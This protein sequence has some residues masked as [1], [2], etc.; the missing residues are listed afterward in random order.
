MEN[1]L[2]L[3]FGFCWSVVRSA[4]CFLVD[5]ECGWRRIAGML[6]PILRILF[7]KIYHERQLLYP[8]NINLHLLVSTTCYLHLPTVHAA[9]RTIPV[10]KQNQN[11]TGFD[12]K[13][14]VDQGACPVS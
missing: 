3:I 2:C 12:K 6:N 4:V 8:K 13:G 14:T 7:N 1:V 11:G 10:Y 5:V 9:L